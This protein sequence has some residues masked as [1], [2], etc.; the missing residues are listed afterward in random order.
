[1]ALGIVQPMI[2]GKYKSDPMRVLFTT[3]DHKSKRSFLDAFE[4]LFSDGRERDSRQIWKVGSNSTTGEKRFCFKKVGVFIRSILSLPG[5]KAIF[6][7]C[8]ISFS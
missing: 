2:A 4:F 7:T 3:D 5:S 8:F 1:M 6:V